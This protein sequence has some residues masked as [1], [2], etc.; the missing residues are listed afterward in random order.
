MNARNL[1][2]P[3]L[4]RT[5]SSVFGGSLKIPVQLFASKNFHHSESCEHGS[6]V[7]E[8]F[9]EE[10]KT[11]EDEPKLEFRGS[12]FDFPC[13]NK[14][15]IDGPEPNYQKIKGGYRLFICKE[16][17][18]FYY[19]GGLLPEFELAYETWGTLN[20][21]RS[22]AIL[23]FTGLS[24]SSHAASQEDNKLPGWWEKF[25]GPGCALDT[26][27]F[28]IICAN[29]LGGCYGTTGPSSINPLT[30]KQYA[31]NFP[32]VSVRDMVTVQKILVESLG[33]K[34]LYAAVGASLGGM[35]SV[36]MAALYPEMVSRLVSL[37]SS[38]KA[39]PTAIAFRYLQRRCIMED[40]IWNRGHYYDGEYPLRGTKLAREIATMTYRSGI[41]WEKRFGRVRIP[42]E[43]PSLCHNFEIEQY[44]EYQGVQYAT[45]LDANTLLY[46]SKAMDLFDLN[47]YFD[48]CEDKNGLNRVRCPTLVMGITTDMLFPVQQQRDLAEG[49][50]RA[51]NESVTYYELNSIYGHDT[52]LLDL[53][54]IGT[55]LKGFLETQMAVNG[56]LSKHRIA[57]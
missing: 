55:A 11:P 18:K 43:P 52:F 26:N 32:M 30:E 15:F 16:P 45:K 35:C 2:R 31:T 24:A 51:G 21:D 14:R 47:E 23:L 39:H 9:I 12:N 53:S 38:S 46:L 1:I 8:K 54:N 29:Q 3:N 34:K 28:F 57:E 44:I 33:I 5:L 13:L 37:S 7:D 40:P 22:N 25:I 56:H 36:T 41:E 6:Q 50:R 10:L 19:N 4:V 49:L 42:G 17:Y 27:K 48:D 20:K